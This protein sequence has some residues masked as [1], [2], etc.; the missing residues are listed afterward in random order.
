MHR[1]LY[2]FK[3]KEFYPFVFVYCVSFKV[4]YVG[5][6][7]ISKLDPIRLNANANVVSLY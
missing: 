6:V 5:S 1:W 2:I 4:K 3:T 7:M